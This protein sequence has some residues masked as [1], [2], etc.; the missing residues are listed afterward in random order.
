MNNKPHAASLSTI[1][2]SSIITLFFTL[3]FPANSVANNH[4][5]IES[6]TKVVLTD[7]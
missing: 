2:I 1:L 3:S 5:F 6:K 4:P 7:K